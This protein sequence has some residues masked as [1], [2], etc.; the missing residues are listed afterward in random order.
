V[1]SGSGEIEL[2]L[3]A[4]ASNDLHAETGSGKV[5]LVGGEGLE[6]STPCV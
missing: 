1:G 4:D 5:R 6:P 2:G 3:P